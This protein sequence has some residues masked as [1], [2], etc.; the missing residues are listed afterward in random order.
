MIELAKGI[1]L[2]RKVKV[3]NEIVAQF[4]TFGE[5]TSTGSSAKTLR[6]RSFKRQS[7]ACLEEMHLKI[8]NLE[9]PKSPVA[10][11]IASY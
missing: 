9:S 4:V 1:D 5:V 11:L 10:M 2:F 8:L 6:K 3:P 7:R